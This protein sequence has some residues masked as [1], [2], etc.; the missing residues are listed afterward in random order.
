MSTQYKLRH[1]SFYM[2]TYQK[3][4]RNIQIHT[5]IAFIVDQADSKIFQRH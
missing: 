2:T 1:D 4:L 5:K 3:V